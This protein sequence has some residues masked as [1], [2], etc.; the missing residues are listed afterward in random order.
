MGSVEKMPLYALLAVLALMAMFFSP[1]RPVAGIALGVGAL[2]AIGAI[3]SSP[4]HHASAPRMALLT[5]AISALVLIGVL[6]LTYAP[7]FVHWTF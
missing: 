1:S 4:R 3:A 5:C 2:S 6:I 7:F